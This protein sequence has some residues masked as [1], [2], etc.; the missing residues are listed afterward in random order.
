MPQLPRRRRPSAQTRAPRPGRPESDHLAPL[1]HLSFSKRPMP[2]FGSTSQFRTPG[3]PL[4]GRAAALVALAAAPAGPTAPGGG[5]R[6][7]PGRK[8]GP[9][10]RPPAPST[11]RPDHGCQPHRHSR[12]RRMPGD[13]PHRRPRRYQYQRWQGLAGNDH[14][15]VP[16]RARRPG[17]SPSTRLS[18][19]SSGRASSRIS[20]RRC[21]PPCRSSW[22]KSRPARPCSNG[23]R[24]R[25]LWPV[26]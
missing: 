9:E 7:L 21:L 16:H 8:Q 11:G 12:S 15:A 20:R 19:K 5:G 10:S 14:P 25:G 22:P 3:R 26:E 23:S 6:P 1:L 17:S 4:E 13:D 18:P 24:K 2:Q